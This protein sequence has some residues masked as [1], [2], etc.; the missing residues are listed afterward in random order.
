MTTAVATEQ[1]LPLGQV[2]E[3]GDRKEGVRRR[4]EERG[5]DKRPGVGG[6]WGVCVGGGRVCCC[7]GEEVVS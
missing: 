6:R 3:G 5:R 7:F 1:L 2:E 4:E